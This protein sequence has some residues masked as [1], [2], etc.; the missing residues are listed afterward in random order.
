MQDPNRKPRR[1]EGKNNRSLFRRTI[2]LMAVLGVG[3]F[4]PLVAQLYR[5]QIVEQEEWEERAADQQTQ[6]VSVAAKRGAIYDREGRA[7]AMSATVYKLILSP[8]GVYGAVDKEK[9]KKDGELDEAAYEKAL[10]DLRKLIV[11]WVSDDLGYDEETL[12]KKL[13]DTGNAYVEL[14]TELEEEDAEKVM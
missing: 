5:L 12:W 8:K 9:Y 14:Y 10:Y 13:E 3:I 7:M 2:F 6:S 11:D 1:S 4:L